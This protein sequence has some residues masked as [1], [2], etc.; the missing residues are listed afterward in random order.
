MNIK[1]I[2]LFGSTGM[3]GTYIKT[4]FTR[5][6]KLNIKLIDIEYRVL[7]ENINKLEPILLSHDL[8]S[9]SCVINCIGMIPQRTNQ[10]EIPNYYIVNSLFP[11]ILSKICKKY[12]SKLIQPSTDCVYSG[13]N[14]NGNYVETDIHDETNE[15]GIS[16]S[17]GEP[18]DCT[19]IRTSIIGLELRN[20]KSFM[21]WVINSI[22]EQK[23]I[24]CWDNHL[25]NGIT[26]L[27]YCKLIEKIIGNNLFWNGI[28]HIYSPES[29]SKYE[30]AQII[31][32]TFFNL[33]HLKH[34]KKSSTIENI[35]KTLN[36]NYK[37]DFEISDLEKQI[38]ELAYFNLI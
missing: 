15:Y 13:K 26:C 1:K 20:K 24:N 23:E 22:K 28:K 37:L 33:E 25:W 17:I 34:I 36:S 9:E 2:L 19:I 21:E 38:N 31:T 12:N 3:L 8:D 29:K 7:L 16:K 6:T 10:N 18:I 32:K 5:D 27:E 35:N 14:P 30:L 11:H 4:Y